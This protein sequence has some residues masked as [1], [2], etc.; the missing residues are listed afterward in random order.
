MHAH[1]TDLRCAVRRLAKTPGFV[2][3]VLLTL[4]LGIGVNTSMYTLVDTLFFRAVPFPEADRMLVVQGTNAQNQHDGFAYAEIEEMRAQSTGA[5]KAFESLT[6]YSY[7]NNTLLMPNRSAERLQ[8]IDATADF[9]T[10]FRVQPMLGR[11]FTADEEV[12]GKNRVAIL[13]YRT[14]QSR[15]GGDPNVIGQVVR[16]NAEPVTIIGVMP[17]SF[18]APLFLGPVD[19]FRP[20]TI[21]PH[22]VKDRFNHFFQAIGRLNPGVTAE[23]AKAQ[24]L[25]LA[26]NWEKDYPQTSKGRGFNLMLPHKAAMDDVSRFIIWLMFGIS[27]AV[28]IVACANIANLQLARATANMKD[29]AVRSALGATRRQLIIHQLTESFLLAIAGGALGVLVAFAVNR[30]FGSAIQL[31]DGASSGTLEL[32]MN[33]RVVL[34]T[35]LASVFSGFFFGLLPAWFVSRGDVNLMLKQQSRG[36]S[37][38]RGARL[39]RNALIVAQ[40]GVALALLGVSGVMIRGFSAMLKRPV[41]WDT[42]H[43]LQANIHLPEQSTYVTDD[44]RRLAIERLTRRLREIPGAEK[45]AIGTTAP[46]FGYSKM[47]PLQ[48]DG[49][50]SDDPSKQPNAGYIMITRDYFATLGIP[51]REG[52]LFAD[53]I[54]AESPPVVIINETMAKHFWPG[55]SAL[56]K[57]IGERDGEKVVWREVIGVVGDIQFA[58]NIANPL[59]M[60]QVYKPMAHEPWGYMFLLVRAQAPGT[61]KNEIRKAVADIDPDVS[62]QEMYTIPEAAQRYER[63]LVVINNTLGGFALLGLVLAAVGLYGVISY[64]VAQRTTEFGIRVALGAT[65]GNVLQ[66]VMRHGFILTT[67]GLVIGVLAGYGLDRVVATTMPR[68]V[69]GSASTL[70]GTAIVLLVVATVACLVPA[71]RATRVSPVTAL[72]AE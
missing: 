66:L 54:K 13:S 26:T 19:L 15:F 17:A 61:F 23:Q 72:R 18:V 44:K 53:D 51:L 38:G 55:Q 48:I 4:A 29:L 64:L 45:T 63:N 11:A 28:L 43:V 71:L 12:P 20:I 57:R 42:E 32:P 1:L 58:L 67:I 46:I 24:L 65:S 47:V 30:I 14:W 62:V 59:T 69:D 31:G 52:R 7:W 21:P 68:M 16:L 25:P 2:A 34:V 35:F 39:I 41:G 3:I 27:A 60:F 40:V 6:T 36:S 37:S 8:A 5:G 22:I 9:F 56:G 49:Q 50:T 33:G 10:T 70:V